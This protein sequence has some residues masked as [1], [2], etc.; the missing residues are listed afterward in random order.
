MWADIYTHYI[1]EKNY[2]LCAFKAINEGIYLIYLS[3]NS[4]GIK[5]FIT[6]DL[7]NNQIINEIKDIYYCD[8]KHYFDKI[9]KRDLILCS[10]TGNNLRVFNFKNW[11]YIISIENIN[12]IGALY[13]SS[14]LYDKNK[15]KNYIITSC[16]NWSNNSSESIKAF[17]FKGN[18]IKE[19]NDSKLAV[20]HI[21]IYFD[22]KLSKNFIIAC[23]RGCVKTFDYDENKLYKKLYEENDNEIY[24]GKLYN[25]FAIRNNKEITEIICSNREGKIKIW[26]FHSGELI[27]IIGVKSQIIFGICLWENKYLFVECWNNTIKKVDL[28]NKVFFEIEGNKSTHNS[29]TIFN[30]PKYGEVLIYGALQDIIIYVNNNGKYK[31]KKILNPTN[32][33]L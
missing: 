2:K 31:I 29:I 20:I 33:Y 8:I 14:I 5:S 13:S 27:K 6:Y 28:S 12:K 23:S 9:N 4:K 26:N 21:D 30:H 17:N 16:M 10:N 25:D 15:S 22:Q 3:K 24:D 7:I 11:D 32:I 18:L 1:Y 19:I